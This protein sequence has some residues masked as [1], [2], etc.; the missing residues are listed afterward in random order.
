GRACALRFAKLGYDIAINY[1]RSESE[2]RDTIGL[3]RA[4][5]AQAILCRADV[6]SDEQV[7]GMIE[8]VEAT[9][10][11]LDVLVNNAG[12]T[13]FIART[14]LDGMTEEAWDR[15]LAVNL[16]G[17]FFC[18]RAARRLLAANGGGAIV[19]ISSVAGISGLGSSIAYCASK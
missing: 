13:S 5:G 3:V 9:F 2:A 15:I 12:T 11:R 14:D 19:S 17:P 8:E 7:R 6:A 16:K 1:S 18:V 10:Q 4:A